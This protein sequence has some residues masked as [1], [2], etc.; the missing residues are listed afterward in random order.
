MLIPL[1]AD[2][3]QQEIKLLALVVF[4]S[5]EWEFLK[6]VDTHGTQRNAADTINDKSQP[7]FSSSWKTRNWDL[8]EVDVVKKSKTLPVEFKL[9]KNC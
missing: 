8:S 4:F 9:V 2:L 7:F 5:D 1:F 3:T 6:V